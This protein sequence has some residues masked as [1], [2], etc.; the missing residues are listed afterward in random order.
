[1]IFPSEEKKHRNKNID[2]KKLYPVYNLQSKGWVMGSRSEPFDPSPVTLQ[3]INGVFA[4]YDQP[5]FPNSLFVPQRRVRVPRRIPL[6]PPP[7]LRAF[8]CL[9]K[10]LPPLPLCLPLPLDPLLIILFFIILTFLPSLLSLTHPPV[11]MT[12]QQL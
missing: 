4:D 9:G 2:H 6:P 3:A 12:S 5:V 7:P 1:M 11:V 10:P 8:N